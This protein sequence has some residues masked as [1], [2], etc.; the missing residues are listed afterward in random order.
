[1]PLIQAYL[2]HL[3][4][5]I[6]LIAGNCDELIARGL[7]LVCAVKERKERVKDFVLTDICPFTLG[8]DVFNEA[9]PAHSYM[10]PVIERNTVLPCSRVR[11][12]YTS[13]DGQ[14]EIRISILQG[15]HTYAE[16]NL[17]LGEMRIAVPKKKKGEEAVD[18][19][20]TYDLNGILAADITVVSTGQSISKTISQNMSEK[21]AEK[22]MAELEKLKIH[23][24]DL[25][26]NKLIM[27]KLISLFEESDLDMREHISFHIRRFEYLLSRQNPRPIQKY[28]EYLKEFI[29]QLES[30]DPF[31]FPA[32]VPDYEE[33]WMDEEDEDNLPEEEETWTN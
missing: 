33:D 25:T 30:Y 13:S 26:E 4:G 32:Q 6:P 11:R 8:T 28:R 20:F 16:D 14:R 15:E 22:R 19:R 29:E 12:Y 2:Q 23:P 5:Q 31:A 7:G 17:N 27:E 1:M 21:E 24:K 10:S 18:V 9:D 3:F